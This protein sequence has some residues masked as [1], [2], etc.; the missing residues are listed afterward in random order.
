MITDMVAA[1]RFLH[2]LR[3]LHRDIKPANVLLCID[4]SIG[5]CT[6]K[7]GDFGISIREEATRAGNSIT[8][9]GGRGAA[10]GTIRYMAPELFDRGVKKYSTASDVYA[11]AVTINQVMTEQVPFDDCDEASVIGVVKSDKE[12]PDFW[13]P[14]LDQSAAP[15]GSGVGGGRGGGGGGE[16]EEQQYEKV[17]DV[18]REATLRSFFGPSWLHEQQQSLWHQEPSKRQSARELDEALR[19]ASSSSSSSSSLTPPPL[20]LFPLLP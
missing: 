11:L 5:V 9:G 16:E 20:L 3:F 1:L 13:S 12:R 15:S 6:A 17:E 19:I 4:A 14:R 2:N 8:R 7:L 10:K 18:S